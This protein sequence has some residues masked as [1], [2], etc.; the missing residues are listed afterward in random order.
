VGVLTGSVASG[1]LFLTFH[2][3]PRA[4]VD[5]VY[6][7]EPVRGTDETA[8]LAPGA[9]ALTADPKPPAL[10]V[11]AAPA[12]SDMLGPSHVTAGGGLA[13]TEVA[14]RA[15]QFT[16]FVQAGRVYGSGVLVDAK[17]SVLTAW[18]VVEGARDIQVSFASG[19]QERAV[20]VDHDAALDLALL[21]V[22][23]PTGRAAPTASVVSTKV[24]EPVYSMGAPRKLKF[25]LSR[26][27]V[28]YTGRPFRD[29]LFIQTDIPTNSGNSG[30]PV[31]N[32]RGEVIALQ[33]FILRDSEG[34]AFAVPIDYAYQRFAP[35]LEQASAGY[36]P[37]RFE[38]WLADRRAAPAPAGDKVD[39]GANLTSP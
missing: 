9:A 16:A 7:I 8:A 24:G 27:M 22:T 3:A 14:D 38:Q 20:L 37:R 35:H 4:D 25:S 15:L 23:P 26:G 6:A 33:S 29:V 10:P 5:A 31:M 30:G 13:A 11:E 39:V 28:S 12:A 32:A 21:R 1:A 18:H 17:G 36:S 19:A 2:A 34:L